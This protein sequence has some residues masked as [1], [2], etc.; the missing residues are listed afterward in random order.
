MHTWLCGSALYQGRAE[1]YTAAPFAPSLPMGGNSTQ[2][3]TRAHIT[4]KDHAHGNLETI[5]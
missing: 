5:A 1:G 2:G 4:E 3:W